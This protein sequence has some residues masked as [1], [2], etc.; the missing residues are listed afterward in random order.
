ME[1]I[2]EDFENAIDAIGSIYEEVFGGFKE[3]P[4][5]IAQTIFK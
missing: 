1:Q 4:L 3:M 2:Y 5:T